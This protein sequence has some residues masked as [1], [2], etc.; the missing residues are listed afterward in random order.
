[1]GSGRI[2]GGAIRKIGDDSALRSP[3]WTAN[4]LTIFDDV[5]GG[6]PRFSSRGKQVCMWHRA[7]Y[8]ISISVRSTKPFTCSQLAYQIATLPKQR[9]DTFKFE[10]F[11]LKNTKLLYLLLYY[12]SVTV[13]LMVLYCTVTAMHT[14]TMACGPSARA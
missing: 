8:L 12:W 6:I 14:E 2:V 9:H 3:T 10:V 1:M 4:M 7:L 5:E 13:A 11:A